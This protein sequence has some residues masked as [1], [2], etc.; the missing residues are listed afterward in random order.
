[1][2]LKLELFRYGH[3]VLGKVL[4]Q[5]EELR[6]NGVLAKKGDFEISSVFA[7]ALGASDLFIRGTD[8][9]NDNDVFVYQFDREEMAIGVC[10]TIKELVAEINSDTDADLGGIVR[11]I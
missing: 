7:P 2:K 5:A 6:G 4:E 10:E 3:L 11:V 1:M 8:A 9:E